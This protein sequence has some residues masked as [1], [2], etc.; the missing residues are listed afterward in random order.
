[1]DKVLVV[2]HVEPYMLPC[3]SSGLGRRI[4]K[5]YTQC[6]DYAEM[7]NIT[8]GDEFE[9]RNPILPEFRNA[10][11]EHWVWA[12]YPHEEFDTKGET[13]IKVSTHHEYAELSDWMHSLYKDKEYVLVGGGEDECL[14]DI[15]ECFVHLNLNVTKGPSSL[16]Y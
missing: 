12:Y 7:I 13:Y 5:H 16:I 4:S 9:D 14:Q 2:V 1:M 3:M 11:Q 15:Y 10:Q 6:D 8:C